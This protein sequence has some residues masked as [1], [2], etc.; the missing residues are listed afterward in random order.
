[1]YFLHGAKDFG[2]LISRVILSNNINLFLKLLINFSAM[3]K[4]QIII[5]KL[6]NLE[7]PHSEYNKSRN[8]MLAYFPAVMKGSVS[9]VRTDTKAAK[10]DLV[11]QN[12]MD[13]LNQNKKSRQPD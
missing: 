8:C 4:N 12:K 11:L 5:I 6:L 1:M 3:M 2:L 10:S 13:E 9:D 7:F